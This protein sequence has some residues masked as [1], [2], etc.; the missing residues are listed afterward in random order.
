M[1]PVVFKIPPRCPLEKK[2]FH[3]GEEFMFVLEG[4]VN[5]LYGRDVYILEKYDAVYFKSNVPHG[6]SNEGEVEAAVLGVM[7]SKQNLY[8]GALFY[9]SFKDQTDVDGE[10]YSGHLT[11]MESSK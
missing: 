1:E 11:A 7:T 3:G 10:E 6:T 4:T 9:R 2:M 5:F 8:N